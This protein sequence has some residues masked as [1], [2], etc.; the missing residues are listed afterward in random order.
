MVCVA[1]I[2]IGSIVPYSAGAFGLHPDSS[3]AGR[4]TER[5]QDSQGKCSGTKTFISSTVSFR[6]SS[7]WVSRVFPD[8]TTYTDLVDVLSNQNTHSPCRLVNNSY[9]TC[10]WPLQ[11][12]RRA[13]VLIEWT[14]GGHV[15]WTLD[16]ERGAALSVG[17][18]PAREQVVHEACGSIG[19]DE[20][21]TVYVSVPE[22]DDYLLMTA[23]LRSPEEA[24]ELRRIRAMLS[25]VSPLG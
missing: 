11:H 15:G 9:S 5:S 20:K 4:S 3:I 1:L 14:V 22:L 12:L 10:G 24:V 17:G 8:R 23:C 13:G 21:V 6:Y 7:C 2:A 16:R 18:S 19:G 25:S